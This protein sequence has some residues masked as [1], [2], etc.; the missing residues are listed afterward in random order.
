MATNTEK[1]VVQV[2]VQGD[3]QLDNLTKK[4]GT[5]TK[6]FGKMAAGVLAAA[7]AFKT[8]SNVIGSSIKTFTAF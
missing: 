7:A 8:I 3:K 4:S 2:V 6:S 5:A 1:V